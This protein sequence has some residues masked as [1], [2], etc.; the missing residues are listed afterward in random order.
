MCSDFRQL[1]GKKSPQSLTAAWQ[2]VLTI[3]SYR[4]LLR[5]EDSISSKL[6]NKPV[7]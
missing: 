3:C 5:P 7:E 6:N 1:W 4:V 2:T